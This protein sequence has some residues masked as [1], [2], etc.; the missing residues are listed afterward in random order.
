MIIEISL[1]TIRVNI[2]APQDLLKEDQLSQQMAAGNVF[3]GFAE[4]KISFPPTFKFDPGSA[5]YDTSQ[6]KRVPSYT[7]S[8]FFVIFLPIQ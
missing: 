8:T 7:V 6:K 4:R 3:K 2:I 5:N 1:S